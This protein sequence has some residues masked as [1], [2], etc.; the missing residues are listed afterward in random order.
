MSYGKKNA[1][2]SIKIEDLGSF[3]FLK[4]KCHKF[5]AALRRLYILTGVQG[6]SKAT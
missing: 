3:L 5:S 2:I 6:E 1:N 4:R